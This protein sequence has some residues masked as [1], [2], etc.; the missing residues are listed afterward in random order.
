MVP[1]HPSLSSSTKLYEM[2]P[3][4]QSL[5]LVLLLLNLAGLKM[6]LTVPMML[7]RIGMRSRS[8]SHGLTCILFEIQSLHSRLVAVF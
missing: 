7:V 5:H 6:L 4:D 3:N 2:N 8:H 1:S